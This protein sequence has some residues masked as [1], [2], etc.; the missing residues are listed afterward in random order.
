MLRALTLVQNVLT[1]GRKRQ[2]FLG[3]RWVVF[4]I[5]RFPSRWLAVRLLALSPHYFFRNLHKGHYVEKEF[6]R[7][8]ASRELLAG[9][10]APYVKATD[11]VLDV[12]CGPGFL[13]KA[14]AGK[15]QHVY[16][17]DISEGV[18]ECAKILCNKE[19][20]SY[21]S[22]LD[23]ITD[24]SLDLAYSFAV[25]NHLTDAALDG[26]LRSIRVK[27]KDG[28]RIVF[29]VGLNENVGRTEQEWREDKS[30]RGRVKY[31]Y[32]MNWFSRSRER[33]SELATGAGLNSIQFAPYIEPDEMFLV[34]TV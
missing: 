24:K 25:V 22:T 23:G 21:I 32:G 18:L 19:N 27:L 29:H 3:A 10:L 26:I 2:S 33:L 9:V 11:V 13:A 7:N 4:L 20:I 30:V 8:Q 34:A 28:G 15:V 1:T 14:V 6:E 5:K 12:G 31:A 16:A 17:Y